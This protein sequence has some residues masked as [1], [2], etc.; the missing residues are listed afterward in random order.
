MKRNNLSYK[1]GFKV[2]AAYFDQLTDRVL[3]NVVGKDNLEHAGFKVPQGYIESLEARILVNCD[4]QSKVVTMIPSSTRWWYPIV[5]TAAAVIIGAVI[6]TNSGSPQV[7]TFADLKDQELTDYLMQSKFMNDEEYLDI[8]YA[9]ND[10]LNITE[11]EENFTDNELL[12]YLVDEV[13]IDQ[14]IRE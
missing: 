1:A 4:E 8:L 9:D 2:P 12:D 7:P 10:K 3:Q 6:L 14:M 13:T 5:A 11:F